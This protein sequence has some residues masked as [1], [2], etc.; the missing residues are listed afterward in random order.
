[1]S[2]VT[3][4]GV[5]LRRHAG[6]IVLIGVALALR[7]L[8]VVAIS[9]GIWFSDS[10]SYITSAA[11]GTLSKIRVD[12]YALFVAPF[13]HLGSAAALIDLQHVI[14]LGMVVALY[15]LL[16][17]RGVPR[18]LAL[19]GV[20]PAALDAYLIVVEHTIMSETI[21]HASVVA[22]ICLLL[23][24]DRL[25]I[26]AALAA[27]LLL[28]YAGVVR[29]VAI[30]FLVVVLAYLLV[31][32]VGWRPL[33]VFLAGWF[34][35]TFGYMAVYD[36]QHGKFAFNQSGGKFLYGKVA[37][38]ADCRTMQGLPAN[39]RR[40]CP[41]PNHRLT[42][43]S[44]LW[45]KKSPIRGV[46]VSKDHLLRDFAVRAIRDKPVIYAKTVIGGV[47]HYFEPGHRIGSND[48]PVQVW[49]FPAD[50]RHWGY[51]GY[52]GP[53]R[54]GIFSREIHHKTTE[55]NKF[56]ARMVSRPHVDVGV[57][58]FLHDYQR[59][60]Y[61]WGPLLALCVVL[62]LVAVVR[63]RG[64]WRTRLDGALL[65]TLVLASL[66]VAQALSVFSYRYQMIAALLLPPAAA[67]AVA[68]MLSGRRR[69]SEPAPPER[70][71]PAAAR[72]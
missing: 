46:S 20:I 2:R 64:P 60:A 24:R 6:L 35:I 15:T 16:V 43:N 66:L 27:G 18:W 54:P 12:G 26:A 51:P 70:A 39:E 1:M 36:H 17:R 28:G 52:R 5:T 55:P 33:V 29:S 63:R 3:A 31:R 42:S 65:A 21:F 9:P 48:Y 4:A 57:S 30:P 38:F 22:M 41:D 40:F 37:R 14:G 67:L 25:G 44:Y 69:A 53:I 47:V 23:W 61:T 32:R 50:P 8:A 34:V 10:N 19:L 59:V 49:Q 71:E 56:V 11:T 58:R 45:G 62:V 72:A 13:W 68:A 7:V